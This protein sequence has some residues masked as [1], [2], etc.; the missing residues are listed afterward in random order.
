MRD[1]NM[2]DSDQVVTPVRELIRVWPDL[3]KKAL[4]KCIEDNL[5]SDKKSDW[6]MDKHSRVTAD[7][8][9]FE[10]TFDYRLLDD[11]FCFISAENVEKEQQQP[12]KADPDVESVATIEHSEEKPIIDPYEEKKED[13]KGEVQKVL[14]RSVLKKN[15]PLMIMIN[16]KKVVEMKVQ[17]RPK[18]L[19]LNQYCNI[20]FILILFHG[21]NYLDILFAWH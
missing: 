10:I 19:S 2:N 7:S 14:T 5:E 3:A 18:Q 9:D 1:V 11:T 6:A 20:I 17:F 13:E 8:P 12:D 15:H 16:E 4:Y 21:R